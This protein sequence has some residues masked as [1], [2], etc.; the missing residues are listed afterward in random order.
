MK[1][2]RRLGKLARGI[3]GAATEQ[4]AAIFFARVLDKRDG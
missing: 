3:F 4:G 1:D 2:P